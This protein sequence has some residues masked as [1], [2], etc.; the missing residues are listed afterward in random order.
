MSSH[1]TTWR[2]EAGALGQNCTGYS[3]A[4]KEGGF[5]ASGAW[6]VEV[7]ESKQVLFFRV[8]VCV[9]ACMI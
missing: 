6:G 1:M 3:T 7:L 4:D 8:K 2:E 5:V 9:M